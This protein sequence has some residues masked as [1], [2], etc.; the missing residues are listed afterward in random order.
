MSDPFLKADEL[1]ETLEQDNVKVKAWSCFF[2]VLC[3]G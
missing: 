3:T 1:E 2:V